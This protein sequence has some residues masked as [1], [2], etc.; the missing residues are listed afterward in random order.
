MDSILLGN[1]LKSPNIRVSDL[2]FQMAVSIAIVCA[3]FDNILSIPLTV[4][5]PDKSL[6]KQ[7]FLPLGINSLNN[8]RSITG[9]LPEGTYA[10]ELKD[11][12]AI[13]TNSDDNDKEWD[14]K[15]GKLLPLDNFTRFE[16][17][18][19]VAKFINAAEYYDDGELIDN[20]DTI[21]NF[22]TIEIRT[23]G[24]LSKVLGE[25][26][27]TEIDVST[28]LFDWIKQLVDTNVEISNA[29]NQMK[30]EYDSI[31]EQ[32]DKYKAGISENIK[33]HEL[34]IQDI[35]NKFTQILYTKKR[36][37]VEL[38]P[39]AT[40]IEHFNEVFE[41]ND[42]NNL[43]K[44]RIDKDKLPDKLD[45]V[46]VPSKRKLQSKA[47]KKRLKRLNK[48]KKESKVKKENDTIEP[49]TELETELDNEQEVE[50][51]T[52]VESEVEKESET[53]VETDASNEDYKITD[54]E[55]V[56]QI[57][58]K[59]ED[60]TEISDESLDQ[61][62]NIEDDFDGLNDDNEEGED[63]EKDEDEDEDD[64]DDDEI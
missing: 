34:I 14:E 56:D 31:R 61:D 55:L 57:L 11:F 39:A 9:I 50:P 42:K 6:I 25:F 5:T 12:T 44:I 16:S 36:K 53:E 48:A 23:P 17:M 60:E 62:E 15:I 30:S 33:N 52:E 58:G 8:G 24:K 13:K 2:L 27:L 37:I 20:Y 54:K 32:R 19:L 18:I 1:K 28:N 49:E 40:K 43:N 10:I 41:E 38:M 4:E 64:D 3:M 47:P 7:T 22:I 46:Y 59:K 51:E 29:Y 35:Q 45:D 21:N 26:K 63:G